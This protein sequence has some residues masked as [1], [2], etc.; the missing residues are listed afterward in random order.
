M[1]KRPPTPPPPDDSLFFTVVNPYPEQPHQTV[2]DSK[3]FAQWIASIV[4]KHNLYAFYHKPRS[5]NMVIVEVSKDGFT[6]FRRLLGEHRWREV[7]RAPNGGHAKE[8]SRIFPCTMSTPRSLQKECWQQVNIEASWLN[9]WSPQE[10]SDIVYPYPLS[11][12]C[13]PPPEDVMRNPLCR[14]FRESL[15]ESSTETSCATPQQSATVPFAYRSLPSVRSSDGDSDLD[16]DSSSGEDLIPMPFRVAPPGLAPLS[17]AVSCAPFVPAIHGADSPKSDSINVVLHSGSDA[18][19]EG[20]SLWVGYGETDA[21]PPPDQC[22][23]HG[24]MC[25]SGICRQHGLRKRDALNEERI[26]KRY[27]EREVWNN[28]RDARQQRR[29]REAREGGWSLGGGGGEAREDGPSWTTMGKAVR[30]TP[31]RFSASVAADLTK[32]VAPP[33]PPHLRK[34]AVKATDGAST[35]P[36]PGLAPPTVASPSSPSSSSD[37]PANSDGQPVADVHPSAT[38]VSGLQSAPVANA[39]N[40]QS[41]AKVLPRQDSGAASVSSATT[42]PTADVPRNS[43]R[44]VQHVQSAPKRW[45]DMLDD[46]EDDEDEDEDRDQDDLDFL[47]RGFTVT[48]IPGAANRE[49]GADS[50]SVFSGWDEDVE[51]F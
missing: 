11:R 12:F 48:E 22:K 18:D 2:H 42:S 3:A 6:D 39:K 24:P 38:N 17:S 34:S 14:P 35:S 15:F 7:L 37:G 13:R 45:A 33:L 50:E 16:Y 43:R 31:G 36:A 23:V 26:R 10:D 30:R 5:P 4:G 32:P 51:P 29:D 41:S 44:R 1:P 9:K 46:D 25:S 8:V 27:Q 40:R 20:E 28:Q 49:D 47:P 19:T 21:P